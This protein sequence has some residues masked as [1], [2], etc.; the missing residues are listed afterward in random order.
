MSY[1]FG[2]YE[3]VWGEPD[4]VLVRGHVSREQFIAAVTSEG[5]NPAR[6]SEP[7]HVW[8]RLVPVR[9]RDYDLEYVFCARGRGAFAVTRA[10][11]V[12][13]GTD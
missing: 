10:D 6:L 12:G 2:E 1:A 5:D 4:Y 13:S 8:A 9:G 11:R 3:H 7:A